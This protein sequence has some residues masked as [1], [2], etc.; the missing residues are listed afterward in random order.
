MRLLLAS[1]LTALLLVI[2]GLLPGCV[3]VE[4][5]CERGKMHVSGFVDGLSDGKVDKAL[6]ALAD[7]MKEP[8][9]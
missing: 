6:K 1:A 3:R 5:D 9:K 2:L 4:V 8:G 7:C